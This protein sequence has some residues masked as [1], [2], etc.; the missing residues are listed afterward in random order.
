VTANDTRLGPPPRDFVS[1]VLHVVSVLR[2]FD[3]SHQQ[4]TLSDV[5]KRTGLDR[6]GARRYLLSLA[7]LGYVVQEGKLF[8]LSPKVLELGY[9]FMSTMPIAYTAQSYLDR[10]THL[11]GQP[12]AIA[13]LDGSDIIHLAR[14]VPSHRILI[15]TV[16]LSRRFPAIGTSTGR[17]LLAFKDDAEREQFIRNASFDGLRKRT[18]TNK[19]ELSA[20]LRK[21]PKRGY[22]IADQDVEEGVRSI[23]VPIANGSSKVIAAL[24]I[25]TNVS[26]V[27][28][29]QLIE[30][31]LPLMLEAS[32]ELR[33]VLATQQTSV[34]EAPP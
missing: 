3:V 34:V 29:K 12:S 31:F 6:A 2:A 7:Y 16:T 26:T 30:E 18:I 20:E 5:S 22:A 13:I 17:V 9:A 14:S 8:R 32:R 19:A 4:M 27:P 24:N 28:K 11:T 21:I 10:L 23:A 1:T 25:I 33:S 15:P